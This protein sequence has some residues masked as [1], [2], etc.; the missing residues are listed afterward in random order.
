MSAPNGRMFGVFI[1][2][3]GE[4]LQTD[5]QPVQR[6]INFKNINNEG[7][8]VCKIFW[9]SVTQKSVMKNAKMVKRKKFD[10]D[11]PLGGAIA[12]RMASLTPP[13]CTRM[14]GLQNLKR[15]NITRKK[16]LYTTKYT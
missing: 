3:F 1:G 2:K 15:I 11:H 10:A 14:I 9:K 16:K 13:P 12:Q 5:G 8:F 4:M 6:K 7:H